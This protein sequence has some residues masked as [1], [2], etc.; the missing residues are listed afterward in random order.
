M[1]ADCFCESK[2]HVGHT[3]LVHGEHFNFEIVFKNDFEFDLVH[4]CLAHN[5]EQL[6][7]LEAAVFELVFN[8][9]DDFYLAIRVFF[10]LN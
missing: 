8:V 2:T 4:D 9:G 1:T 6:A 7:L 10:E 3:V 5:D